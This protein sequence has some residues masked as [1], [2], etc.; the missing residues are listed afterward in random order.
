MKDVMGIINLMENEGFLKEL[1]YYRPV[2]AVPTGGRY[3]II[4][5]VLSNM[6]NSGIRNV[7]IIT[8]Q[9]YRSLLDHMGRGKEWDLDRKRDGL[10]FL[11][12]AQIHYPMSI[13]RWDLRHFCSHLDYIDFSRQKYVIISGS[14]MICNLDYKAAFRFHQETKADMT[15][16]YK[17]STGRENLAHCT[18]IETE[19]DG[20]VVDMAMNP[21]DRKAGKVFMEMAIMEKSLLVDLINGCASRGDCDF[22]KDG[23]IKNLHKL[24]IYGYRHQG[25]LAYIDSIQSYYQHNMDLL[26]PEI[27]QELFFKHGVIYTK[28]A[29]GAPTRYKETAKTQNALV[30]N[31]CVIE[32]TVEN[33]ILFRGVKIHKG[34]CVRNSVIMESCVV[35]EDALLENV[36]SEKQVVVT[37]GKHLKGEKHYPLVI[38]K[39]TVI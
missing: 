26:T 8:P 35:E 37:R 1:S 29:D 32:G 33:S 28:V 21:V 13:Y 6:V 27:G 36:I 12:P 16:L 2:A 14:N 20:R 38:R 23:L 17:V 5:F 10:F 22:V 24:K 4:D 31:E 3:R 39:R 15:I 30:A 19:D 11:P 18:V 9:K 7:G 34:A 25:Y